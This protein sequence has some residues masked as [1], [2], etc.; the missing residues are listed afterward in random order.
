ME[1]SGNKSKFNTDQNLV[2]SNCANEEQFKESHTFGT[3]ISDNVRFLNQIQDWD[4]WNLTKTN[5]G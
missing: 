2:D 5:H 1:S 3:K 4:L